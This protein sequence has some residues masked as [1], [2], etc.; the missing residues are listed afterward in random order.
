MGIAIFDEVLQKIIERLRAD[1]GVTALVGQN[2][3]SEIPQ[4]NPL[5][6]IRVSSDTDEFDTK[7]SDGFDAII[8]FDFWSGHCGN[9]EVNEIAQ[10]IYAAFQNKPLDLTVKSLCLQHQ[11]YTTV[12]E[13]D[14]LSTHGIMTFRHLYSN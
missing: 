4:D 13:S 8:T 6:Y 1:A 3:F 7:G 11:R 10:A 2:S 14:D 9:K 12:I 5:A